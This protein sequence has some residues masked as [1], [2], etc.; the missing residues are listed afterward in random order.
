[1]RISGPGTSWD[2]G[3]DMACPRKFQD[4]QGVQDVLDVPDVQ[5]VQDV[6]LDV[7]LDVLDVL[8][9]RD[10]RDMLHVRDVMNVQDVRDALDVQDVW[11]VRKIL[12]FASHSLS[13]SSEGQFRG[14]AMYTTQLVPGVGL[15]L[16]TLLRQV[17]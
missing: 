1:M 11:D 3:I 14:Q 13:P 2:F 15:T 9:V 6:L 12:I 5:D 17:H 4:L 7:L 8:D 10:V 16:S